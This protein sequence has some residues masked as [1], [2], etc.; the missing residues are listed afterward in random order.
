MSATPVPPRRQTCGIPFACR[1]AHRPARFPVAMRVR[2]GRD[3]RPACALP[4]LAAEPLRPRAP[5]GLGAAGRR[6]WRDVTAEFDPRGDELRIL[7]EACREVD[8]IVRAEA[9]LAAAPS[10]LV[11]GQPRPGR[12][13]PAAGGA[14]AAPQPAGPAA[15][16]AGPRRAGGR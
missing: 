4:R 6:L 5:A 11:A 3:E 2:R 9:E 15:A 14:G 16:L 8:L 1:C 10:L 7:E 12:C 13:A